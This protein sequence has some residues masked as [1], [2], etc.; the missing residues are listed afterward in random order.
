M[1]GKTRF[2]SMTEHRLAFAWYIKYPL[3]A[4]ALGPMRYE[5]PVGADRV[6]EDAT[7]QFGEA[8]AAIWPTGH[9]EE[10]EEY[11]IEL[12]DASFSEYVEWKNATGGRL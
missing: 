6:I 8:P 7:E 10:V 11:E 9:T 12:A 2:S 3:D 5:D 4:Y 1:R